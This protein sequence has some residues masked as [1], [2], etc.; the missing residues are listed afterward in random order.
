[1]CYFHNPI[2]KHLIYFKERL[3]LKHQALRQTD[4]APRI[5]HCLGEDKYFILF[6]LDGTITMVHTEDPNSPLFLST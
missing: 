3:Q 5:V 2:L 4:V 1:M 6:F